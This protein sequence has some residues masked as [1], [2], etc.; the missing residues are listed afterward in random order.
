M[1]R[2]VDFFPVIKSPLTHI[3]MMLPLYHQ[4]N[5][6]AIAVRHTLHTLPQVLRL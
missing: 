6:A 2:F 1:F 5:P 4:P 3:K